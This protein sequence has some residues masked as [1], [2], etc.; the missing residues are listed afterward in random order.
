LP[1]D[2]LAVSAFLRVTDMQGHQPMPSQSA[3]RHTP[4]P[5]RFLS[6][7]AQAERYGKSIKTVERWGKDPEMSMPPEYDFNGPHRDEAEL[8]AWERSRVASKD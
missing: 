6:R 3:Q 1:A 8:E 5:R 2:N 4:K 7:R